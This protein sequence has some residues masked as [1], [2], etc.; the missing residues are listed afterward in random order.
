MKAISIITIFIAFLACGCAGKTRA[1]IPQPDGPAHEL[2]LGRVHFLTASTAVRAQGKRVLD[3]NAELLK[4]A[5]TTVVI[6]EGHCDERESDA[7]NLQLGDRRARSVMAE[8]MKRGIAP[9]RLIIVSKGELEPLA[10]GHHEAAWRENRRVEFV[11][12]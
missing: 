8:M 5:S 11:V 6:L 3:R 10:T 12:R 4:A 2:R 7:F 1:R 9:E